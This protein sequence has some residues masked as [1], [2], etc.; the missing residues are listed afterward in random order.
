MDA[1]IIKQKASEERDYVVGMRRYFHKYPE[2]S[3]NEYDTSKKIQEELRKTGIEYAAYENTNAVVGLIRG[4]NDG[5]TVA[6][7]ADMDALPINEENT[8]PYR[9]VHEGVMHACGHDGHTAVLLGTAKILYGMREKLHGNVKLLFQ[10][11]EETVGGAETMISLGCMDNPKVDYV[12]GLHMDPAIECGTLRS[13]AGVFNANGDEIEIKVKGKKSHG[14]SPE[15]GI[16]AIYVASG[17][18]VD[19]Q[20]LVSRRLSPFDNA[21]MTIGKIEGGTASNVIADQVRMSIMLRT[22]DSAVRKHMKEWIKKIAELTAEAN[23]AACEVNFYPSYTAAINDKECTD[24]VEAVSKELLGDNT[25][26]SVEHPF[27]GLEDFAYFLKKAR[28]AFYQLGCG[29]KAKDI[30]ASTH[31]S[32]FDMDEDALINGVMMQTGI[33]CRLIGEK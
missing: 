1:K 23:G 18:V 28:G 21:V 33:V 9:S 5:K 22:T 8:V 15:L 4:V 24:L 14:A 2:L 7:R 19:L 13:K 26:H 20:S 30:T 29:N 12:F 27:L 11:A 32:N 16:D 31:T 17:I 6:L 25:Y 3:E 10:P